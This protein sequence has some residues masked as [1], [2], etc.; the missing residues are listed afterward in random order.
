LLNG[1]EK[2]FECQEKK[3]PIL[4]ASVVDIPTHTTDIRFGSF[5]DI[6]RV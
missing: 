6:R 1:F 4:G 2:R 5:E 3:Y